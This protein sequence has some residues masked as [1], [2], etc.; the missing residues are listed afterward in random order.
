MEPKPEILHVDPG[1]LKVPETRVTA[2]WDP[3]RWELFMQSIRQV[4]VKEPIKCIRVGEELWISD[5]VHRAVAAKKAGLKTVPVYVEVGSE[6]DVDLQ[7]LILN[8]L[9]GKTKPSEMVA[10]IG[11]LDKEHHLTPEQIEQAVGLSGAWC[12][13][14]LKV[15]QASPELVDLVE[16]GK[17]PVGV[18]FEIAK[19]DSFDVQVRMASMAETYGWSVDEAR[20]MAESVRE[21]MMKPPTERVPMEELKPKGVPC[22]IC[23]KEKDPKELVSPIICHECWGMMGALLSEAR[24]AVKATVTPPPTKPEGTE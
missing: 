7:N 2:S 21:E 10:V 8:W 13:K 22:R 12:R 5:G 23:G 14:L 18:A 4:G 11:K 16:E 17:I 20:R 24:A 9:R 6:R 1:T 3:E 15:S 19:F